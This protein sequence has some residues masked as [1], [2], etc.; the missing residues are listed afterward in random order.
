MT[1][2]YAELYAKHLSRFLQAGSDLTIV[3]I[4][5][6][7]RT[8]LSVWCDLFPEARVIWLDID[9]SNYQGNLSELKQRGAFQHNQPEVFE[10]D[11][12]LDTRSTWAGSCRAGELM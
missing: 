8:G 9:L 12:F 7:Q 11:Q 1:H 4:G 5:I 3:E 6:L 10:F 2:G